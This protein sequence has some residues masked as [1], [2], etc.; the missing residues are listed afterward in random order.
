MS[1]LFTQSVTIA[2]ADI[3]ELGHVNNTVYLRWAQD[4]ATAHWRA[5]ASAAMQA[6]YVW[7]AT[8]HEI[9]YRAS[10]E[11]GDEA[12]AR[13]WIEDAPRG[14]LW[15]RHVEIGKPG[16]RAAAELTSVWCLLDAATRKVKRVPPEMIQIFGA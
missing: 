1:E 8:R 12:E 14:P 15:T 10:L 13:T 7:V 5:R 4:I 9:D 6:R 3:D 11:L 16:Q 2:P